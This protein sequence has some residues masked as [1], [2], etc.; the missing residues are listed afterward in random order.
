MRK[1]TGAIPFD[2]FAAILDDLLREVK[3]AAQTR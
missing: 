1:E 2:A 3:P